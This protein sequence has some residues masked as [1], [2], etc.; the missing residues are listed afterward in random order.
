MDRIKKLIK[1]EGFRELFV[2]GIVGVL[3]TVVNYVVYYAVTRLAALITGAAPEHAVL[4]A[5]GNVLSWIASVTFAFWANKKYVFRSP[6]WGK[7]T[8]KKEIP[9]FV[10]ARVFSLVLDIAIVELMVHAMGVSDLISKLVSN[11][12]VIVVNYFLSKFWIFRKKS[13]K[14]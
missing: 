13:E 8:L 5:V 11:I 2:Y 6:D 10:A 3:T 12:L 9:G 14:Q 7:A 4:I 1:S